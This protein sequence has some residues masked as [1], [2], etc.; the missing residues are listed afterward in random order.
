MFLQV[1]GRFVQCFF[2]R[3]LTNLLNIFRRLLVKIN[4]FR[5]LLANLLTVFCRL[6]FG[7]FIEYFY[8]HLAILLTVFCRLVANLLHVFADFCP[9][10]WICFR[11]L[12]A[13]SC[14]KRMVLYVFERI[15]INTSYHYYLSY[16]T[17]ITNATVAQDFTGVAIAHASCLGWLSRSACC[18]HVREW[19]WHV[20]T[21]VWLSVTCSFMCVFERDTCVH[22]RDWA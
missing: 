9:I 2:F 10:Y 15:A 19:T 4:I 12:L 3:L 21:C 22:V 14:A 8:R 16:V 18:V 5:R 17:Q 1:L 20:H 13:N 6:N 11:R 7:Q